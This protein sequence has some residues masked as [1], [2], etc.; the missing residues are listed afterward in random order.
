VRDSE[1]ENVHSEDDSLP[2]EEETDSQRSVTDDMSQKRK[3]VLCCALW[4]VCYLY[5]IV[6]ARL[7]THN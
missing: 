5:M 4:F 3:Y 7:V 2:Q 6:D 1:E